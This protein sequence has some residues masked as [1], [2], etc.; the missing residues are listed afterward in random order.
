MDHKIIDDNGALV[1]FFEGV[2]N[3]AISFV[4]HFDSQANIL[5]GINTAI[6]G[7]SLT[8]INSGRFTPPLSVIVFFSFCSLICAL[9]SIHPPRFMRKR[10]QSESLFYNKKIN[11]FPNAEA[12]A[13]AVKEMLNN[14]DEFILNYTTEIYNLYKYSYRPKRDLFK[15]ARNFLITGIMLGL[16]L[17]IISSAV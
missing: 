11:S 15:I 5:I 7:I 17:F 3:K 10:G 2:K 8:I 6:I 9:Y 4:L 16:L 14:K 1:D 12:Y 13:A